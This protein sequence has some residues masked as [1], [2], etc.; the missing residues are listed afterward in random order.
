MEPEPEPE[1][2]TALRRGHTN[3]SAV[4]FAAPL[5]A[6]LEI[7]SASSSDEEGGLGGAGVGGGGAQRAG[8]SEGTPPHAASRARGLEAA[9]SRLAVLARLAPYR[10]VRHVLEEREPIDHEKFFDTVQCAA[11]FIDISGFSKI[12]EKL[13]AKHSLEG[14]E[15]LAKHLNQNLGRIVDRITSCGG[16]VIKF[17]GDAALCLFPVQPGADLAAQTLRATQLSLECITTLETESVVV[18]G[19]KLTAHS[20]LGIGEATGFF[21]GGARYNQVQRAEYTPIGAPMTQVRPHSPSLP[22]SPHNPAPS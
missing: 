15:M 11:L 8:P 9:R 19:V 3:S 12:T 13:V 14:A 10:L 18:E 20:G 7:A 1:D 6:R 17:A 2:S 5:P 21:T 22:A 4:S 16:D